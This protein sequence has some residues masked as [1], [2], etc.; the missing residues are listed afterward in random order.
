MIEALQAGYESGKAL[1][2]IAQGLSSLKTETAV[3]QAT[4]DIKRHVL[5]TQKALDTADRAHASDLKQIDKLEAEILRLQDWAAAKDNYELKAITSRAYAY[6]IKSNAGM[7]GDAHW[8]CQPC[9]DTTQKCV[10]QWSGK[11]I[12]PAGITGMFATWHCPRCQSEIHVGRNQ[13]PLDT[14][15]GNEAPPSHK[16]DYSSK[17]IV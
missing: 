16:I 13:S 11:T 2:G 9:F 4:I 1:I 15:A 17:G 12:S 8:V 5:E 3:A 7:A 10:L 14:N 6:V